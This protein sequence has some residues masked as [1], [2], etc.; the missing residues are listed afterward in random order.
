MEKE[1]IRYKF[2]DRHE[3]MKLLHDNDM[4]RYFNMLELSVEESKRVARCL[5]YA[6][7]MHGCIVIR[8]RGSQW[9]YL[10]KT[11]KYGNDLQLTTWDEHGPVGDVRVSCEEDFSYL[12]NGEIV[13]CAENSQDSC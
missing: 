12:M 2:M 7:Y 6:A 5:M 11:P 13:A 8:R 9:H 1:L 10:H 4:E 3:Q